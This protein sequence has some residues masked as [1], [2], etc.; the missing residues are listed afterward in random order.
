MSISRK[1]E[2]IYQCRKGW[3]QTGESH[4]FRWINKQIEKTKK[5]KTTKQQFQQKKKEKG[6]KTS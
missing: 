6:L 3:Y 5:K 1:I 4:P 2:E